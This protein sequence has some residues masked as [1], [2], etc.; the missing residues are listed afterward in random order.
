MIM[1]EC[2]FSLKIADIIFLSYSIYNIKQIEY[3][4]IILIVYNYKYKYK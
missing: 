3:F 1:K 2:N 4:F